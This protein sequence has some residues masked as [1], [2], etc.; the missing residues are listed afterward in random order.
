MKRV[1]L[2]IVLVALLIGFSP[3][4]GQKGKGGNGKG[5][6]GASDT[7]PAVFDFADCGGGAPC[8]TGDGTYEDGVDHV[9]AEFVAAGNPILDLRDRRSTRVAQILWGVCEPTGEG[10]VP[11]MPQIRLNHTQLAD[12]LGVLVEDRFLGM[13]IGD[14]AFSRLGI[15]FAPEE[16]KAEAWSIRFSEALDFEGTPGSRVQVTRESDTQWQ[17][18]GTRNDSSQAVAII[19]RVHNGA[20]RA[21]GA[22][23]F[24]IDI[25]IGCSGC[26][27]AP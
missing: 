25:A 22:C 13:G 4:L 17:V 11:D 20:F 21:V 3:A 15:S 16:K 1:F 2:Q 5:G 10:I 12:D 23:P 18:S 14:V 24:Q 27:P 9:T 6:G 7:H 19:G 26:P 8:I